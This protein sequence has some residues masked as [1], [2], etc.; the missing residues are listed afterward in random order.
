MPGL[1][2]FACI[3][4]AQGCKRRFRSQRGRT[5]HVRTFHTNHNV[6]EQTQRRSA[7]NT[8]E[9][10]GSEEVIISDDFF[11]G[12]A[13]SDREPE[14]Q[15]PLRSPSPEPQSLPSGRKQIIHPH[16]NGLPCDDKG[17]FLPPGTPPIPRS[18][19]MPENW[20]P[21]DDELQFR[22]G[23]FLY[24]KAEMSAGDIDNLM[25]IWALSKSEENS[26]TPF[27]S[28]EHMYAAIDAI[29]HGD[30]PWKS[31]TT[32][33]V[34][35]LQP[36][37][38]SWQLADY[39]VWYRDPSVVL[40]NILDNPDFDGE[41]DYAPFIEVDESEKRHW[42]EFMSGNF[43]YR[44]A[45]DIYEADNSTEGAMYCPVILGADKTT[46]SVATGSVEY[47]PLYLSTGAIHNTARRAHRNAVVPIGFLAIP[48]CDRKEDNTTLF[49]KFKRQLYHASISTILSSLRASMSKPVIRRCP[50]GHYRRVIYDL[51][52]FIA[53]YPEQVLLA[54][55]V[56]G[57][58]PRC[59]ALPDNLDG[60]R[61]R[62][63]RG[64]TD[65]LLDT[66]A[67]KMLWDE[68][69]IDDD[70]LPFTHD[71]PRADIHEIL[72]PDLL[73]QII[74][75]TFK[76]HL[77]TW[78]GEYLILEHGEAHA[79]EIMDDIDRRIAA[80][81]LFPKLRRF[82]HGRRFKQW[83]G[84]DSKALMKVYIA[85]ICGHVPDDMVRTFSAFLDVCYLARRSDISEAT[86][87]A[88]D[89]ALAK[90]Y[91]YREI[92]RTSGV[93]PTGFSLP[94]QHSLSHYHHLIQ[95]F[96]APNGICSSITESRHITA[97][98]KPWRCSNRYEALGQMLLGLSRLDKL[99]AARVNFESRGMLPPSSAPRRHQK[100][101][102]DD[103]NNSD[104]DG[105][106]VDH[107]PAVRHVEM[108]EG[109][110][111]LAWTRIWGYPRQLEDLA[112]HIQEPRLPE[113]TRRFLF[114]QLNT[115]I[116][117]DDV[118]L[119]ECP[120][121]SSKISV[122]HSAVATF[123]APSDECGLRGMLR[124]RI[125]SC[126]SWRK[127]GPRRDCAFVVEDE[128]KPGMKGMNAARVKLLFSFTHQDKS[129]PC[130]LVEWF[131]TVGRSRDSVT[132]MWKVRPD[133]RQN[134]RLQAIIHLDSVL[135]GA[136][137]L[138]VFGGEFLPV[139]FSYEDSLDA[140]A[141]YYINHFA[142]HHTHEIVF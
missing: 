12:D 49:R 71:F 17:E 81:P 122:F 58:C 137:L 33:Y 76:D 62:R 59:T 127:K 126:P 142:D 63:T 77:V 108:V 121:I 9:R 42:N 109:N 135:R 21:F 22:T 61:G 133:T 51:A 70:I 56:Q 67:S 23:D 13:F 105:E 46:V 4:A 119:D 98:K 32:S 80:S 41:I 141:T 93:R 84:D 55:T 44:H 53:D 132:G 3:F 48:K 47:H 1:F 87:K 60:L 36:D 10:A 117:S 52:A 15:Q 99:H 115:N 101:I 8:A 100:T 19:A 120:S 131:S 39:E 110:V 43:S 2:K 118:T 104:N 35:Q 69:G 45:T 73:H 25:D 97:V 129:Y 72:T 66:L 138:P 140:F 31:F 7:P 112:A 102:D 6:V 106:V 75:G 30:A 64:F 107:S 28:H 111:V 26:Y 68:Y 136:H 134:H 37:A 88:F 96:G 116:S 83:T 124:E 103:G 11:D 86:L 18:A 95:E 85:A 89:I 50:D 82:P 40:K 14:A 130:A 20:D 90:F 38:P 128:D 5:T 113:L 92:F 24:R 65:E 125:R 78:V 54:G 27:S 91:T 16:L 74:K 79:N 139:N 57:W 94:R 123:F 29:K 34:G 114:D